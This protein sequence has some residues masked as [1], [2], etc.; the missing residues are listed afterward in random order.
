MDTGHDGRA[1]GV[2]PSPPGARERIETTHALHESLLDGDV[3]HAVERDRLLVLVDPAG[4]EVDAPVVDDAVLRLKLLHGAAA[5]TRLDGQAQ[6]ARD[7]R[8]A[9]T[10]P[11]HRIPRAMQLIKLHHDLARRPVRHRVR[12]RRDAPQVHGVNLAESEADFHRGNGK[13]RT[14]V[15]RG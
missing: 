7:Q 10:R 2:S 15:A 1:P 4:L 11:A 8:H 12:H 3:L 5:E 6:A 9:H 13:M 14:A